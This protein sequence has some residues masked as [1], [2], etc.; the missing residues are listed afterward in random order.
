MGEWGHEVMYV[1][2]ERYSLVSLTHGEH[3][4]MQDE[5]REQLAS[6]GFAIPDTDK[7]DHLF[8]F[9]P[10]PSGWG[11]QGLYQASPRG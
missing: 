10:T 6:H 9:T 2:G 5:D 4:Q 1:Q 11:Q 7:L 3:Q 8:K